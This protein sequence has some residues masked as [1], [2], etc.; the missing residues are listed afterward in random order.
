WPEQH[1]FSNSQ[2]EHRLPNLSR[3]RAERAGVE[4]VGLHAEPGQQPLSF[5]R[6]RF[7]TSG[8][9][10]PEVAPAS[11]K[12]PGPHRA[13]KNQYAQYSPH[14]YRDGDRADAGRNQS[15]AD[16]ACPS[17]RSGATNEKGA[18]PVTEQNRSGAGGLQKMAAERSA[19]P[20]R[21]RFSSRRRKVQ[22]ET[23]LRPGIGFADGR[24]LE[25]GKGR[26]G[27]DTNRDLSNGVTALQKIFPEGRSPNHRRQA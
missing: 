6:A 14:S 5:G 19:P 10:D 17:P 27:P 22:E 20:L 2:R 15:R 25:T 4:S 11:G 8:E 7:R 16:R 12:D 26:F 18:C 13:N 1:R 23:A 3:R 24:N 21:R 9:A